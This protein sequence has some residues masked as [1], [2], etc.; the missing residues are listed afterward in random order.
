MEKLEEGAAEEGAAEESAAE[1]SAV[2]EST[3]EEGA[4]VVK[5]DEEEFED[6]PQHVS[7]FR[8]R[9]SQRLEKRTDDSALKSRLL[10]SLVQGDPKKMSH[11]DSDLKSVLDVR[12]YFSKCVLESEFRARFIK[13][14]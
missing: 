4:V 7:E 10:E 8:M 11:K 6:E 14:L 13:P 12:F 1:K 2:E 5:S 3:F 9:W